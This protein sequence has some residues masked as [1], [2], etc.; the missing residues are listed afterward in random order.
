[1]L[2]IS[3]IDNLKLMNVSLTKELEQIVDEKVKSGLYNSAS[4]FG[5][6]RHFVYLAATMVYRVSLFVIANL[7]FLIL[8]VAIYAIGYEYDSA[9][10]LYPEFKRMGYDWGMYV[11]G[12]RWER[13]GKFLLIVGG[14]TD[15]VIL[16]GWYQ[17]RQSKEAIALDLHE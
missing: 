17:K 6:I 16:L 11:Y 10:N 7:V 14:I 5:V 9:H 8:V 12:Q 3:T 13:I 1:M 4:R 2:F 15:A